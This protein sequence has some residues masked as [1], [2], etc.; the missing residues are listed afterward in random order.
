MWILLLKKYQTSK[1]NQ[2]AL[3]RDNTKDNLQSGQNFYHCFIKMIR[4]EYP[5]L[6]MSLYK[7]HL[8][9]FENQS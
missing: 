8:E 9:Y 7:Y 1:F 2:I 4:S 3:I 6:N 5:S